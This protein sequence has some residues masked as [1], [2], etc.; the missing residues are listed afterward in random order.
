[1]S[2]NLYAVIMAGGIGSRLWP[3]SRSTMPK[4]FLDLVGERTML[5]ETVERIA[6]LVPLERVLI[7]VGED[8]VA[9]VREQVPDLPAENVL[10]EPGPRNTAPAIG[11]AT[12][13]VRDRDPRALMAVFPA[14]HRIADGARFRHAIAAAAEVAR[15]QYLVTLGI[16][17]TFAHTGYGYI[18]RGDPLGTGDGRVQGLPI[19]HVKRFAE[20]PDAA[21]AERFVASGEYYWNGGIFVWRAD[22]IGREIERQMPALHAEMEALARVWDRPNRD[23]V[24]AAAWDRV[25]RQSIDYGVMEGAGRVATMPVD[26]G[27]DDV[28]SWATLSE[29]LPADSQ[30]NVQRGLGEKI[31]LDTSDTYVYAADGRLVAAVGLE[32]LVIIATPDA[33]LVCPKSRAQDV[34]DVV[35][36]IESRGLD[37]YL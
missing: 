23:Q 25:P 17:P 27:W 22:T 31:L 18:Q 24:L 30:G 32:G 9:T 2:E 16:T 33:I 5:Q 3:R 15:D 8:H 34:R 19:Y 1:M 4:Q 6:P 11:L 29:L 14:D 37:R 26:I 10:H 21:T 35:Q 28:G 36:K 13:A 12:V 7:V 20:K